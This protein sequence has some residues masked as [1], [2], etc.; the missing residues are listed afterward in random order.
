MVQKTQK[1]QKI[2]KRKTSSVDSHRLRRIN[3][4]VI[5]GFIGDAVR[6]A[7]TE[8]IDDDEPLE[9]AFYKLDEELDILSDDAS[10]YFDT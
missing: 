3:K 2:H 9:Y 7:N 10:E 8:M 1:P 6:I 4:F 5:D